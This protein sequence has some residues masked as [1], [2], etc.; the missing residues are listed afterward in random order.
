MN[1]IQ[2]IGQDRRLMITL[3]YY[4]YLETIQIEH[5]EIIL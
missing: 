5:L 2:E 4:S 1:T 3:M